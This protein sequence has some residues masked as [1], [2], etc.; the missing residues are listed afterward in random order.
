VSRFWILA[1][2]FAATALTLTLAF[3]L[4]SWAFDFRRY[5][6][7]EERMRRV[8]EQQPTIEQL[9]AGLEAEGA[10]VLSSPE[11]PE[12]I[13]KAIA[14]FGRDRVPELRRK[15]ARW[16][17]VRV[18]RAADMLYFVFFDDQGVMRDFVCVGA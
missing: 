10:S 15:A 3:L 4:G 6:Q 2:A 12:E 7:H 18:Y 1:G 14:R 5:S 11:T 9:T 8:L 17:R 16:P 13:E